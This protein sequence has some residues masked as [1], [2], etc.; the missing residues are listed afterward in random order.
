LKKETT[1]QQQIKISFGGI[2][3]SR[4]VLF[5]PLFL[6]H[7]AKQSAENTSACSKASQAFSGTFSAPKPP[8][9]CPEPSTE[10]VEPDLALHQGFLEPSPE[11]PDMALTFSGTF[12][13]T[14]LN[15][16]WLCT[17]ASEPSRESR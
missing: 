9:P 4:S 5:L 11:P 1:Q 12:S 8:R 14:L 13:R 7:A 16:T 6:K 15:L 3:N 10:P 17:K 2:P